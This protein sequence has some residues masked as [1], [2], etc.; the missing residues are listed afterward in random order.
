MMSDFRRCTTLVTEWIVSEKFITY[1]LPLRIISALGC[2]ST[3]GI[4]FAPDL[5]Q[6]LI[7]VSS[8]GTVYQADASTMGTWAT[9]MVGHHAPITFA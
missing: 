8:A 9:W 4:L 6:M 3:V 5:R 1:L 2:S 7:T